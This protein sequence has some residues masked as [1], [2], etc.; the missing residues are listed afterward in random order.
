MINLLI[1]VLKYDIF[2]NYLLHKYEFYLK[3][4]L[5]DETNTQ[6]SELQFVNQ[7]TKLLILLPCVVGLTI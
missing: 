6:P 5:I 2:F 4:N 7:K 3:T 1:F